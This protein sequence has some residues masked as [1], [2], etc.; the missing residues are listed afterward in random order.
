MYTLILMAA[1]YGNFP[2]CP[3]YISEV[4]TVCVEPY[5]D[6]VTVCEPGERHMH[7]DKVVCINLPE[8]RLRK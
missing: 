8:A 3:Q 6:G 1:L 4:T 7:G 5:A 2:V